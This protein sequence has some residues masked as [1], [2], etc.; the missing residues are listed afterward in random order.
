MKNPEQ[1]TRKNDFIR[2]RWFS[3]TQSESQTSEKKKRKEFH[4]QK[5]FQE[6]C[7][8]YQ[9]ASMTLSLT[10]SIFFCATHTRNRRNNISTPHDQSR[11]LESKSPGRFFVH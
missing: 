4:N 7:C 2:E 1:K 5:I 6:L 9:S 10:Q 8:V 3:S 11:T